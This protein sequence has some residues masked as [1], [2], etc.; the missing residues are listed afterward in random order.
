MHMLELPHVSEL[1]FREG[2]Q[3]RGLEEYYVQTLV[4]KY[5]LLRS[6]F[7]VSALEQN[8]PLQVPLS[9]NPYLSYQYLVHIG[10]VREGILYDLIHALPPHTLKD[11][12]EQQILDAYPAWRDA[13]MYVGILQAH[14]MHMHRMY[15]GDLSAVAR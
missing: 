8:M 13:Y 7:T 14:F 6:G 15:F 2:L 10:R 4:D 3:Q 1:N 12:S 11:Y 5:L 9:Q